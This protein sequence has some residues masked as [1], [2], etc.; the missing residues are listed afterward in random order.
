VGLIGLRTRRLRS[1]LSALGISLGIAAV[2]AVTGI[3][4]S[5]QAHLLDRLDRLGSNLIT[6]TPGK[7]IDQTVVPLPKESVTMLGAIPSVEKASATSD[8]K[9]AV[10]RTNLIPDNQTNG[11]SVR[12]LARPGHRKAP[13][14]GS[15][16]SRGTGPR[17]HRPRAEGLDRTPGKERRRGVVR[18]PRHPSAQ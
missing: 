12:P 2:V 16:L 10:Y 7:D 6:V 3:S 17:R 18:R 8:T 11:L 4:S 13:G 1:A 15:R 9:A 14:D 5:N